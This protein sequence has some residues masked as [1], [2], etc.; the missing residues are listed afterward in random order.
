[1]CNTDDGLL[2]GFDKFIDG[3]LNE[4][5]TLSIKGRSGLIK[6]QKLWL[7]NEGSG[8]GDSLLLSTGEFDASL[9][10]ECVET[11]WEL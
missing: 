1:M 6:K 2:T 11:F 8:N 3:L 4:M 5:F 7:S 10:N 9:T